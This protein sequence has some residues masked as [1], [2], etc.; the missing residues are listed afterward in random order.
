ML[1]HIWNYG[2]FGNENCLDVVG[3]NHE[4]IL[5]K[6]WG[7]W[8]VSIVSFEEFDEFCSRYRVKGISL[9]S[10]NL[11]NGLKSMASLQLPTTYSTCGAMGYPPRGIENETWQAIKGMFD[12]PRTA[13]VNGG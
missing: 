3:S 8:F 5:E 13:I 10:H 1:F 7:M 4:T 11:A 2:L 12:E 9:C 6:D